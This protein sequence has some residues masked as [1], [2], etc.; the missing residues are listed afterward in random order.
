MASNACGGPHRKSLVGE[1]SPIPSNHKTRFVSCAIFTKWLP[2]RCEN[3]NENSHGNY[4]N[5]VSFSR[6]VWRPWG[7]FQL[8]IRV[9]IFR[10]SRNFSHGVFRRNAQPHIF[11]MRWSGDWGCALTSKIAL[12]CT[13]RIACQKLFAVFFK[14]EKCFPFMSTS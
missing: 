8:L 9:R 1:A 14:H 10:E 6:H 4:E 2:W 7:H 11:N 12:W 3:R 13:T 5:G